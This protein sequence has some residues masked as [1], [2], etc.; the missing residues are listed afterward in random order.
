MKNQFTW[1]PTGCWRQLVSL[2]TAI[3]PLPDGSL[4]L[5]TEIP[6]QSLSLFLQCGAQLI[7]TAMK[8]TSGILPFGIIG[9]EFAEDSLA[10]LTTLVKLPGSA[11]DIQVGSWRLWWKSHGEERWPEG[12]SASRV[13]SPQTQERSEIGWLHFPAIFFDPCPPQL[14]PRRMKPCWRCCGSVSCPAH[15]ISRWKAE[16]AASVMLDL[17]LQNFPAF[18]G[19]AGAQQHHS[20]NPVQRA[21]SSLVPASA[22]SPLMGASLSFGS[23]VVGHKS[24]GLTP[25]APVSLWEKIL[26]LWLQS[27]SAPQKCRC[28]LGNSPV[29]KKMW[30]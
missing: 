23:A 6:A 19:A 12:Q 5:G 16:T 17:Q 3:L 21:W 7:P 11:A 27:Q 24:I 26:A 28:T 13:S 9:W 18:I 4:P 1:S 15:G 8:M 10:E 25:T 14:L 20:A 22:N 2:Y 29:E 30:I